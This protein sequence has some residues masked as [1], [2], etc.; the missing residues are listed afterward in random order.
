MSAP[1][2]ENYVL[3]SG[4]GLSV[5]F[6]VIWLAGDL[7]NLAGGVLAGVLPTMI[8]IAVYVSATCLGWEGAAGEGER[9]H[10]FSRKARSIAPA[11]AGRVCGPSSSRATLEGGRLA[12]FLESN[13][14]ERGGWVPYW[15]VW[16]VVAALARWRRRVLLAPSPQPTVVDRDHPTT[17][18]FRLWGMSELKSRLSA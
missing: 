16:S 10:T 1:V 9:W 5:A 13:A 14:R 3:K 8:L 4:E 18:S 6:I 17:Y 15:A 2:I 7:T 11:P 12:T